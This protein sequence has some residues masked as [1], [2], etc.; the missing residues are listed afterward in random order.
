MPCLTMTIHDRQHDELATAESS[1][2]SSILV[3]RRTFVA[4]QRADE[5]LGRTAQV[6]NPR[7]RHDSVDTPGRA[8]LKS[9]IKA[10]AVVAGGEAST[11]K[12]HSGSARHD[13]TGLFERVR[14]H[15]VQR[16]HAAAAL[17]GGGRGR[18]RPHHPCRVLG[19]EPQ[20]P[21]GVEHHVRPSDRLMRAPTAR[22]GVHGRTDDIPHGLHAPCHAHEGG[23]LRGSKAA[24]PAA[25][26]WP[27][28]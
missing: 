17:R 23:R 3:R 18:R 16:A 10:S 5:A 15:R 9:A 1:T 13:D 24:A 2:Q 25:A 4:L 21:R 26:K 19:F 14:A 22:E 7:C 8:R 12:S 28:I 11:I 6:G 27:A 20:L